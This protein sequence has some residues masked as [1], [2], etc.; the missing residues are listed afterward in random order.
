YKELFDLHSYGKD[1]DRVLVHQIT[2]RCRE[3][4]SKSG[5]V[6]ADISNIISLDTEGATDQILLLRGELHR[7]QRLLEYRTR[8][9][10]APIFTKEM[11]IRDFYRAAFGKTWIALTEHENGQLICMRKDG[12]E[13]WRYQPGSSFHFPCILVTA[14]G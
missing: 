3:L 1:R 7:G 4:D 11:E 8:L 6:V 5:E 12:A 13:L 9:D 14:D 2:R 10:T